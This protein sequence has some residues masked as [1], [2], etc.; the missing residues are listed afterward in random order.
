ME[1]WIKQ[2]GAGLDYVLKTQ[3]FYFKFRNCQLAFD[4]A[5]RELNVPPLLDVEDMVEH[6]N[7]DPLSIMTY[8]SYY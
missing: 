3:K 7:P 4:T 2:I 6:D 1:S 5:E 8:V